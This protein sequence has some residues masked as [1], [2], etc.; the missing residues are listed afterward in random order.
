MKQSVILLHGLARSSRAMN[1]M[2]R[3][4]VAGGYHCVN[5]SYPS[6]KMAIEVLSAKAIETALAQCQGSE[7]IHFVTH[8]MGGIL[9]RYYLSNNKL[10][11]LSRVVMLGP[12]N[13]GSEVVDKLKHLSIFRWFNGPAGLQLGTDE[14]SVPVMLSRSG[15][16]FDACE[17]G[18]FLGTRTVNPLLSLLIPSDND[19][20]VSVSSTR[21]NGMKSHLCLPVTHTFMASNK[22]VIAQTLHFLQ[23]GEFKMR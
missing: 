1:A 11:K 20:K 7:R 9:L 10:E 13:Q 14:L 23:H 12:P 21:L 18:L 4:L 22:S 17:L 8:S 16:E 5:H 15:R 19:G 6:A 3:A 2:E